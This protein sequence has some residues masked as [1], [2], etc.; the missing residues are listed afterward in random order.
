MAKITVMGSF[1]VDVMAR[2]PHLPRPGETVKGS[3]FKIGPGGKGSNQAGAA[4]SMVD[5]ESSENQILVT[6]GA[7]EYITDQEI[8]RARDAI[9]DADILLTQM[10]TSLSAVEAAVDM[11]SAAGVRV[12]LNPAPARTV[13]DDLLQKVD[14]LTPNEIEAEILSG[15]KVVDADTAETAARVL[16]GRGVR[17]VVVTMGVKGALVVTPES[18]DLVEGYIVDA[19]DTTGAGDAFNGG[20]ATA[21]AEGCDIL[22]AARFGNATGALSVMRMGTAPA[23]PGRSDIEAFISRAGRSAVTR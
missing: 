17:N 15:I 4:L 23:M 6:L 16:M 8:A 9:V 12:I 18:C 14:V 21:L 1:V 22:T 3:V 2:G 13:S 11:A 5:E 7:C 10:E 20:F 19:I